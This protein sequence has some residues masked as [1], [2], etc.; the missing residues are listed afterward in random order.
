GTFHHLY[1][2]GMPNSVLALGA[3][4][5]ALEIVPLCLIGFEAWGNI[6]LARQRDQANWLGA[7][8][9]PIYFFVA[10]AFW[11]LV[12]AGIFGFLINPPV[13]LYYMQG[14]NT[15]PVHGHTA[16]FGVYGMLGLG[17]MLFTLK[18]LRPQ[19]RWKERTMK[20][21]FWA[22]NGGLVLM[23]ALSMLPIGLMQ[24][25]ASVRVGVW[26]ARS[27]EFLQTPLM[28]T[29]RWLRMF[30]DTVFAIG[31][32]VLA[33][34]VFATVIGPR[35]RREIVIGAPEVD[36]LPGAAAEGASYRS[37]TKL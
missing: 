11:N 3:V 33:L 35:R 25:W 10:V 4:F 26:Y 13:A 34:V 8:K 12:G 23:V 2:T 28:D 36:V 5:S 22:I 32:V 7:Y 21:A 20:I 15:T 14:M 27:A 31:A 18:A 30:G 1:F 29:L 37:I 24:V 17:L 16:L 9:W 6:R 19:V